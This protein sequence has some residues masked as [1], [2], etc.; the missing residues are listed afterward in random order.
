MSDSSH[1]LR[2][3]MVEEIPHALAGPDP[4]ELLAQADVV[5]EM[6]LEFVPLRVTMRT[7]HRP[8]RFGM[9]LGLIHEISDPGRNGFDQDLRAFAFQELEHVEV[10]VSLRQLSPELP[11]NL[12]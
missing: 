3:A 4:P 10:A 5:G 7:I 6:L 12:H 1:V 8:L 9:G 2:S 11:G